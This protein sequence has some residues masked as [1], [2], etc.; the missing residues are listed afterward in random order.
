MRRLL[1]ALWVTLLGCGAACGLMCVACLLFLDLGYVTAFWW[2]V[3]ALGFLA[4]GMMLQW[5]VD[6]EDRRTRRAMYRQD[7]GQ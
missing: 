4:L 5:H 3:S 2:F 1:T 6:F 7:G